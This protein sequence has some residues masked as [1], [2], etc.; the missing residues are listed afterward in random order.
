[1]QIDMEKLADNLQRL[2]EDDLL[3]VVEMVHNNKTSDTYTK[4]D[5]ERMSISILSHAPRSLSRRRANWLAVQKVNS[6]STFILYLIPW[7]ECCGTFHKRNYQLEI[8][9]QKL[10]PN[11]IY[12]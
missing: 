10:S 3:Q 4:N 1:M 8:Q 11:A 2:G 6:M 5:V 9:N 7:Y 12:R